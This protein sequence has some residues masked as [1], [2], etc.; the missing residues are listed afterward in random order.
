M[1]NKFLKNL[2]NFKGKSPLTP[3]INSYSKLQN[4]AKST[5]NNDSYN[6]PTHHINTRQNFNYSPLDVSS[7]RQTVKLLI[8]KRSRP[9]NESMRPRTRR[10]RRR[11]TPIKKYHTNISEITRFRSNRSQHFLTSSEK[12]LARYV[13]R[14]GRAR[15]YDGRRGAAIAPCDVCHS[16]LRRHHTAVPHNWG[17]SIA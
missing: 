7:H 14:W 3:S 16:Y 8:S 11:N 6:P 5:L 13:D 15:K 4:C 12:Y 17:C 9:S 1:S 10:G 2:K